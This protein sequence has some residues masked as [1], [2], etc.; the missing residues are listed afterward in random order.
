MFISVKEYKSVF[1]ALGYQFKISDCVV[2]NNELLALLIKAVGTEE[3]EAEE[4]QKQWDPALRQKGVVQWN[5]KSKQWAVLV[6][7]GLEP[8][9]IGVSHEPASHIV[10]IEQY[11]SDFEPDE[12]EEIGG[13][14]SLILGSGSPYKDTPLGRFNASE[15]ADGAFLRGAVTKLKTVDGYLYACG[16]LRSFGKRIG[17]GKWIS[18]TQ[19]FPTVDPSKG[20]RV[21][22]NDFGA[23]SEYDI[24]LAGFRGDVWHFNG[25]KSRQI[26]IPT[27]IDLETICCAGNGEV[28]ISG[29]KGMTFHGRGDR[30][31]RVENE[32]PYEDPVDLHFRDMVWYEKKVWATNDDGLWVIE[33]NTI[34]EANVPDWVQDCSGNL[35]VG[36]GVLLLA[37]EGGA[38]FRENGEWHKILLFDE[39]EALLAAEEGGGASS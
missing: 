24:Y 33:N 35:S 36:N 27:N 37:G 1:R 23:F 10:S 30:W 25:I 22:F 26:P 5:R 9:L 20:L 6:E 4:E 14:R 2:R 16:T 29:A 13:M 8:M 18:Y 32:E 11:L 15:G 21:G 19:H 38:V 31:E 28:Y 3:L 17:Q 39:M 34:K 7:G 12:R